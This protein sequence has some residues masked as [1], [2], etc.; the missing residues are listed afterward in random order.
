MLQRV[1]ITLFSVG[2]QYRKQ[3]VINPPCRRGM[4]RTFSSEIPSKTFNSMHNQIPIPVNTNNTYESEN[5]HNMKIFTKIIRENSSDTFE[6]MACAVHFARIGDYYNMVIIV[7]RM[8]KLFAKLRDFR[9]V[10]H[11]ISQIESYNISPT[12]SIHAIIHMYV[13]EGDFPHTLFWFGKMKTAGIQPNETIYNILIDMFVTK[14]DV[15]NALDFF[16]KK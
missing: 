3:L 13:K 12:K 14:R 5:E 8:D 2:T 11:L 16:K 15:V 6:H 7:K 9:Y 4:I 10:Q 1:K